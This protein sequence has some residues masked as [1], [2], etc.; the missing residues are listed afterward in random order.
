[1]RPLPA[2]IFGENAFGQPGN[3]NLVNGLI[4][5]L[6]ICAILFFGQQILIP[7]V[8]AILLSLLLT[9]LVK[10]LQKI[11]I[12]KTIAIIVVV[13]FAFT[14]LFAV[15]AVVTT[16]LTNLAGDLPQYETNL[17]EKARTLKFATS[18]GDTI[19]KA[20]NVLKDLQTELQQPQ[21]LPQSSLPSVRPIPVE[22]RETSF[23]PLDPV[24]SV[25]ALLIHPMTQLGIVVLMVV[26]ILFNKEDLRN[27]LIRLAGTGDLNRTTLALDDAGKRLSLLFTAQILINSLTGAFIA[28]ALSIIGIP[29]AILWGVLTAILRFVPYVGTLMSSVF[30]IIIAVAIGDGWSLAV[31]T[32]GIVVVAEI[33]V[34]QVLEPLFFGK[35]TGLS[36]VAIVASAAFWAALWGPIGLILATPMTIGLLVIGRNI[37]SLDFFEVL[38]GSEP[39]LKSD[40][41]FYQ[42][43]LASDPVEAAELAD[44]YVRV[45]RFDEF[46][47]K[48]AIPGLMLANNDQLRGVLSVV[49]QTAIAHT[50]SEVLDEV[51]VNDDDNGDNPPTVLLV[52][53]HGPLNFAATLAF[54]ALL[55]TKNVPHQMLPQDAIAPGRF[56]KIDMS[57]LESLYLCYLTSP[58][59]A[60]YSYLLRRI[61]SFSKDARVISVAW[62]TD[63]DHVQ[64]QSPAS[65]VSAL[66]LNTIKATKQGESGDPVVAGAAQI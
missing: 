39:V 9:P 42:R 53:A 38:L 8:L 36:P 52:S 56:P 29:G 28:I 20:A 32:A 63:A 24:I 14:V 43:L 54:S 35:M 33:I 60:K 49:R 46:L 4:I 19:E 40:H 25:V 3:Q 16:T 30:P 13:C 57:K 41:A 2:K 59:E 6:A 45:E 18:G 50:F 61:S 5:F 37:E 66:P 27:R 48:V 58:S 64:M 7:A 10:M 47:N 34:G 44:E 17:R 51:V 21:Q 23:G 65:V 15:A 1:M 22:V 55:K 62:S 26:L 12:P 11:R 31:M